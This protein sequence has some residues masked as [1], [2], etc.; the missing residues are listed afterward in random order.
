MELAAINRAVTPTS[1]RAFA[2]WFETTALRRLIPAEKQMLT[3]QRFW[4][5]MGFL[6]EEKIGAI[7]DKAERGYSVTRLSAD[8]VKELDDGDLTFL[9]SY[10]ENN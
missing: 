4:D 7:I 10:H 9:E 8:Q 2:E 3:S 1:K 5:H 6:N